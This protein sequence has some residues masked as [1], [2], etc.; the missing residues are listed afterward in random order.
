MC[1]AVIEGHQIHFDQLLPVID[2]SHIKSIFENLE[3]NPTQLA[4]RHDRDAMLVDL[5]PESDTHWLSS[6][7]IEALVLNRPEAA[8]KIKDALIERGQDALDGVHWLAIKN[9]VD[10]VDALM[11]MRAKPALVHVNMA[12]GQNQLNLAMHLLAH[13]Q[14]HVHP[15]TDAASTIMEAAARLGDLKRVKELIHQVDPPLGPPT[16]VARALSVAAT[17]SLPVMVC[18]LDALRATY[19][20]DAAQEAM[21]QALIHAA[22]CNQMAIASRLLP[23][24]NPNFENGKALR[25][26]MESGHTAMA[27]LLAP[28]TDVEKVRKTWS[29]VKIKRWDLINELVLLAPPEVRERWMTKQPDRF[30]EA[31]ARLRAQKAHEIQPEI[32]NRRRPRSRA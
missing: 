10:V 32:S 26:A 19:T 18:L 1:A 7:L 8:V 13:F 29:S 17:T 6:A 24:A 9:R 2:F 20:P 11:E 14:P 4:V 21:D 15:A 22:A 12:C 5:L 23:M 31:I 30:R 25:L 28:L 3:P 27:E 16:A